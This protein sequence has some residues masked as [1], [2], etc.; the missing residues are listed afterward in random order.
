MSP[1]G[2]VRRVSFV[3]PYLRCLGRSCV[4]FMG[5]VVYAQ[6]LCAWLVR[7]VRCGAW[8]LCLLRDG[9]GC[10]G[11]RCGTPRY[12]AFKSITGKPPV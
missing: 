4:G 11:V 10:G 3:W 1:G 2:L 5:I 12:S 9:E 8:L 6:G 7:V